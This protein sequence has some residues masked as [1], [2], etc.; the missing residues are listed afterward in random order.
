M[1]DPTSINILQ[2]LQTRLTLAISFIT[3]L[4]LD[5]AHSLTS[6]LH[7]YYTLMNKAIVYAKDANV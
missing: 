6:L 2:S 3:H 4:Q 5:S 7:H 1:L